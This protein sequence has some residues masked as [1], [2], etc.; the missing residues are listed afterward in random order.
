ML[1]CTVCSKCSVSV[2]SNGGQLLRAEGGTRETLPVPEKVMPSKSTAETAFTQGNP[3]TVLLHC[4]IFTMGAYAFEG[5]CMALLQATRH[6]CIRDGRGV[7]R[8][9][10]PLDPGADRRLALTC[11]CF[12]FHVQARDAFD[13]RE[14]NKPPPII[15]QRQGHAPS[16]RRLLNS[17]ATSVQ[18][19]GNTPS[20]SDCKLTYGRQT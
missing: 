4:I 18:I 16:G 1:G 9:V 17:V 14:D 8:R 20:P 13:G 10:T 2:Q 3:L 19:A 12:T 15:I 7:A 5:H 11:A 6:I